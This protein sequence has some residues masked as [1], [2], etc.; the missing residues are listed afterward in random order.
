MTARAISAVAE[1]LVNMATHH[2][3]KCIHGV[4]PTCYW[5]C[6]PSELMPQAYLF[7][8]EL[9][10]LMGCCLSNVQ[11][12]VLQELRVTLL[13]VMQDEICSKRSVGE[14]YAGMKTGG[15]MDG[16]RSPAGN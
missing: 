7:K 8:D 9:S 4:G 3:W 6:T 5:T 11:N 2:D 15:W 10:I 13:I 1:L 12:P 16:K 14:L